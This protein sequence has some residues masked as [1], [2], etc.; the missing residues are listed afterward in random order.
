MTVSR[1][2][3]PRLRLC[4]LLTAFKPD[5]NAPADAMSTVQ[6]MVNASATSTTVRPERPPDRR[7][8]L[9]RNDILPVLSLLNCPFLP[10]GTT[11]P[12]SRIAASVKSNC[13]FLKRERT[14][15]GRNGN[16][17]V[18]RLLHG[19]LGFAGDDG[20]ITQTRLRRRRA[21]SSRSHRLALRGRGRAG[22]R[23]ESAGD[24]QNS[25]AAATHSG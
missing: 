24:E 16:R 6:T 2:T 13:E 7:S 25:S 4:A 17:G 1:N 18:H 23:D 15:A 9:H 19:C 20:A 10:Q 21:R 5:E 8:F 11:D 12:S 22:G 3:V 14:C